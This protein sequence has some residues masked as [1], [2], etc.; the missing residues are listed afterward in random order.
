MNK[1]FQKMQCLSETKEIKSQEIYEKLFDKKCDKRYLESAVQKFYLLNKKAFSFLGIQLEMIG[2]G[3][4]LSIKFTS[5][6]FIGAIPVKMPY[7]G[8]AHKDF[9]IVPRFDKSEDVFSDLTHLL[10]RLNFSISPEFFNEEKLA[11][12]LQLRPPLYYEA[13]KFIE[14]FEKAQ[15]QK[16]VKFEVVKREFNFPK[17]NTDWATYSK[18]SYDAKKTLIYPTTDSILSINHKEWKQLVYVFNIAKKIILQQNI[19]ASIRFKYR[20]RI[21]ALQKKNY[22]IEEIKTDEI[23]IHSSDPQKIK[24]VKYQA[25]VLLKNGSYS[26]V[27]HRFSL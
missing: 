9:Q 7:D 1:L 12:P 19:P 13:V 26:C 18:R 23:V 16:W 21:L 3:G 22:L 11:L 17:M 15:K 20:D 25:N 14:L 8:I 24:D 27:G 6:G 2:T 5:S 10:S 4:D